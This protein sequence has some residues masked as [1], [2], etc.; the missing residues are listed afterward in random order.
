MIISFYPFRGK[1]GKLKIAVGWSE[2]LESFYAYAMALDDEPDLE[3]FRYGVGAKRREIQTL[4]QLAERV[5]PF[6]EIP[7]ET[8]RRLRQD[9][10]RSNKPLLVSP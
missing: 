1:E 2:S 7:D 5:G 4:E 6:G 9:C 8:M 3:L 10:S